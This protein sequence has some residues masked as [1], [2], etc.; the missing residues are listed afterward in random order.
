MNEKVSETWLIDYWKTKRELAMTQG[1][2]R[3]MVQEEPIAAK[4]ASL[5]QHEVPDFS[6]SQNTN[7]RS[8]IQKQ[9]ELQKMI[10]DQ[11]GSS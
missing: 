11:G 10:L 3:K 2:A 7:V 6:S 8:N 9:L 1:T 4:S 5:S